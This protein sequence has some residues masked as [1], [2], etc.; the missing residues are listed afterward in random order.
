MAQCRLTLEQRRLTMAQCRLTEARTLT[1]TQWNL[2]ICA[3]E[4]HTGMVE[5]HPGAHSGDLLT[6]ES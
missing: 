2:A 1:M 5:T 6:V 4:A 3:V